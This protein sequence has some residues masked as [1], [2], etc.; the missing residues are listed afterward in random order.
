[1]NNGVN[2]EDKNKLGSN[3]KISPAE[4]Y[5]DENGKVNEKALKT[6]EKKSDNNT[7]NN[8]S[9]KPVISPVNEDS[10]KNNNSINNNEIKQKKKLSLTPLFIIIIFILI[11]LVFY[12]YVD[13]NRT[14]QELKYD[15]NVISNFD[16]NK[17]LDINSTL[18]QEL[19]NKV[20]TNIYEDLA[21]NE[22]NDNMKLYLAY[23]N[24]NVNSFYDSNCNL[25]N[26]ASTVNLSCDKN[27]FTPKAFTEESLQTSLK[28]L[29]GENTNIKNDNI[30]LGNTCLGGY[31]YIEKRGEYVEGKC[32]A[33]S[34]TSLKVDKT[35]K[36]AI[37]EDNYIKITE[38]V[39]YISND[40][41]LVPEHLKD[42]YYIYTFKLNT[43]YNYSYVSKEYKSKY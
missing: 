3:V 18:V 43:N 40:R 41:L 16:K 14:F 8:V 36:N 23:R 30:Q 17:K 27:S 32:T 34:T 12:E 9:I 20:S 31:Q 11:G 19:Y 24:L 2:E 22:L 21:N 7:N 6:E 1:M 26:S 15:C 28:S 42:G 39:K 38:E 35:L 33:N 4:S 29:F 37:R 5:Y 13:K 10:N 25:F